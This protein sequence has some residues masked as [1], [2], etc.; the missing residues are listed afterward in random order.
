MWIPVSGTAEPGATV[1]VRLDDGRTETVTAD[2]RGRWSLRFPAVKPGDHVYVVHETVDGFASA[3]VSTSFLV[4]QGPASG[5]DGGD[6]G[7]GG[8]DGDGSGGSGGNGTGSGAPGTGSGTGT[9]AGSGIGVTAGGGATP[10]FVSGGALAFTGSTVLPWMVVGA[11]LFAL[12][13]GMVGA[14]RGLSRIRASRR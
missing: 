11:G 5:T 7:S 4:L 2:A 8:T 14:S 6:S 3:P 9:S 10:T 13:L 1:T 12:G